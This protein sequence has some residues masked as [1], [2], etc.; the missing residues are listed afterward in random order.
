MHAP[1]SAD[2]N[3]LFGCCLLLVI[4]LVMR[5]TQHITATYYQRF[6]ILLHGL[7]NMDTSSSSLRDFE[8]AL[9]RT[10]ARCTRKYY[11]FKMSITVLYILLFFFLMFVFT[12][13]GLPMMTKAMLSLVLPSLIILLQKKMKDSGV[14]RGDEALLRMSR[15]VLEP[16]C[17][18]S[19]DSRTGRVSDRFR[20]AYHGTA[21][22]GQNKDTDVRDSYA[23]LFFYLFI[24]FCSLLAEPNRLIQYLPFAPSTL[25]KVQN[26]YIY[27]PG[28]MWGR[29][30]LFSV[31]L[32]LI[33]AGVPT[34]EA[35]RLVA[36][37]DLHGDYN[38]TL[39]VL[40][41]AGLID[42]FDN[43][44]G[45]D[46]ILVQ[47]GDIL[48]VGP[49][50]LLIVRFL[51]K[52]GAQ[53]RKAGGDVHQLLGNHEIRNFRGDF[54]KV[55]PGSLQKDGGQAGREFILSNKTKLGMYLRTRKAVFHY[56]PFL[57][58]HG[59][60]STATS[61]MIT[62]LSKVE[63]F[64]TLLREALVTGT[65]SSDLARSGLDLSESDGLVA[66]PILVRTILTVKCDSLVKV[67]DKHFKGI[68][69]VVVG[70]VPH[71]YDDWRLC[72][73]R[74]IDID[75]RMSRW[76]KGDP[77]HV[78]ALEIEES[79]WHTQLLQAT[80]E[81]MDPVPEKV[82]RREHFLRL[83]GFI[84]GLV[85]AMV[86]IMYLLRLREARMARTA[87]LRGD[88][89]SGAR[90]YGQ[91]NNNNKNNKASK[92]INAGCP[93]GSG[94][95]VCRKIIFSSFYIIPD[96]F[97]FCLSDTCL[98]ISLLC[99]LHLKDAACERFLKPKKVVNPDELLPLGENDR[100]IRVVFHAQLKDDIEGSFHQLQC[101]NVIVKAKLGVE[102]ECLSLADAVAN[103][104]MMHQVGQASKKEP[105]LTM[106]SVVDDSGHTS[107]LL[108][109]R[110]IA[111][112][113]PLMSQLCS[114]FSNEYVSFHGPA[115]V[116]AAPSAPVKGKK[117]ETVP[118]ASKERRKPSI[119][120][121]FVGACLSRVNFRFEDILHVSSKRYEVDL[122]E[123]GKSFVETWVELVCQDA[124][125]AP[126]AVLQKYRPVSVVIHSVELSQA[127]LQDED[128]MGIL[129]DTNVLDGAKEDGGEPSSTQ[130]QTQEGIY[131][132]IECLGHTITTPALPVRRCIAGASEDKSDLFR[133]LIFLGHSTP[134]RVL[135][136]IMFEQVSVS[137]HRQEQRSVVLD[138]EESTAKLHF[139]SGSF[140]VK[141]LVEHNQT[142]FCESLQ[143]LPNRTSLTTTESTLTCA[144]TVSMS[145]DFFTPLEPVQHVN[146]LGEPTERSF[147]TRGILVMPYAPDWAEAAIGALLRELLKSKRAG[148]DSDVTAYVQPQMEEVAEDTP[149]PK[150]GRE[151]KKS[152]SGEGARASSRGSSK[153]SK[154][155]KRGKAAPPT[156]P[157]P[158]TRTAFEEPFKVISP[159]GISGFEVID[160]EI[161]LICLEGPA[162]EVHH[163]LKST[164]EACRYPP[165]LKVMYNS[166]IFI[167]SRR[168]VKF[169]PLVTPPD[170]TKRPKVH[171]EVRAGVVVH[172]DGPA[173]PEIKDAEAGVE[174][175]AGGTG[176]RVHRI[177]LREPLSS[178]AKQQRYL[179]HRTLSESCLSCFQKL[180]H[181]SKCENIWDA[182]RRQFFPCAADLISLERSFGQTLD[183]TDIFAR[184]NY[185][186]LSAIMAEDATR[187]F[188]DTATTVPRIH[189]VDVANLTE[190]DVGLLTSF[191]GRL[192]SKP[193]RIPGEV[194]RRYSTCM[195]M[196]TQEGQAV[197]CAFPRDVP[198]GTIKYELEGQVVR[199]G[200]ILLLYVMEFHSIS[201][202]ITCSKNPNYEEFLRRRRWCEKQLALLAGEH[203]RRER[204]L[205]TLNK[206]AQIRDLPM[207]VE[208]GDSPSDSDGEY[209]DPPPEDRATSIGSTEAEFTE[210]WENRFAKPR[211]TKSSTI[212]QYINRQEKPTADD[213][214]MMW[215]MYRQRAPPVEKPKP[216]GPSLLRLYTMYGR[217]QTFHF[218]Y[219]KY[220]M[221]LDR[222]QH[223]PIEK[224]DIF[225]LCSCVS[226][227]GSPFFAL[228][229]LFFFLP[230]VLAKINK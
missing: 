126:P 148:P 224:E 97:A 222:D 52:L 130:T 25:S 128:E 154:K 112:S 28:I 84:I 27:L 199:V 158:P 106:K 17:G 164:A 212:L 42:E 200:R 4:T 167:P 40:R 22:V 155:G 114:G 49:D 81:Y 14:E 63:E 183:L 147:M 7:Q 188:Y 37:G 54:S 125:L 32:L 198:G 34:S 107:F 59:G 86:I 58:M 57:F 70:H 123:S 31:G 217:K 89:L 215:Q 140:S 173:V 23:S 50:D 36:V 176:G 77:G 141:P 181:L 186:N 56:G 151:K 75:F 66:N 180:F 133:T 214:A 160:G 187:T 72:G 121:N 116:E 39:A 229:S 15:T 35:R 156:P 162:A 83:C 210:Y 192:L 227:A 101:S 138:D 53:A 223:D 146:E 38:Q 122:G 131:A 26:I 144:C 182:L 87:G 92:F 94:G 170:L 71:D 120:S 216:I 64:N 119:A 211:S 104:V 19:Y 45:A 196:C 185:V 111:L 226:R 29:L 225:L 137:V 174:A 55:D 96:Y 76:K 46:A 205:P 135:Q 93:H 62:S 139:G 143:L 60:F 165:E 115:A 195:W 166:E 102:E 127:L 108:A 124:P 213:Y 79:N 74:L 145:L 218:V 65:V 85:F 51:M 24:Y 219:L 21:V 204:R 16:S 73:G 150:K 153:E 159:E 179:L 78:A 18:L 9:Q 91:P 113:L 169:P 206:G 30:I 8:R 190:E 172:E 95:I 11:S 171:E 90:P 33:V 168:Y 100:S 201:N 43:W 12:D 109:Q 203:K 117:G 207:H 68:Q 69:S 5:E 191:Q 118:K 197:L 110:R 20:P 161:R 3:S 41:L 177:R 136:R 230:L 209:A 13:T 99:L 98:S 105:N 184:T 157:P 61:E 80:V 82:G 152:A 221:A 134:L 44:G 88:G 1:L 220:G 142:Y 193:K 6:T 163:I 149:A 189:E 202:S 132:V 208:A 48:D 228:F 194:T 175:E 129:S 47:T 103:E 67:L 2:S 10:A 178:L